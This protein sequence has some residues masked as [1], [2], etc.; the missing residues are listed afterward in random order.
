[1]TSPGQRHRKWIGATEQ[2]LTQIYF[3]RTLSIPTMSPSPLHNLSWVQMEILIFINFD[4][5]TNS[6]MSWAGGTTLLLAGQKTIHKG[7]NTRVCG[8]YSDRF[9]PVQSPRPKVN[10][11]VIWRAL[12]P[13]DEE[14][15]KINPLTSL[16]VTRAL[17]HWDLGARGST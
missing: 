4:Q 14:M 15:K 5:D 16:L 12:A 2:D 17:K 7:M 13:M 1:M 10:V 6:C 11:N 8:K 3:Q 9:Y